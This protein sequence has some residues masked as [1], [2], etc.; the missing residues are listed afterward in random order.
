MVN[1]LNEDIERRAQVIEKALDKVIDKI[2]EETS[3]VKPPIDIPLGELS[4]SPM[5][6]VTKQWLDGIKEVHP[7]LPYSIIKKAHEEDYDH[8]IVEKVSITD[9]AYIALYRVAE[10]IYQ[11][12]EKHKVLIIQSEHYFGNVDTPF[13]MCFVKHDE[14]CIEGFYVDADWEYFKININE[15]KWKPCYNNELLVI[16]TDK[17]GNNIEQ[18]W[19]CILRET[20][21]EDVSALKFFDWI[22]KEERCIHKVFNDWNK[23]KYELYEFFKDMH[24]YTAI[25]FLKDNPGFLLRDALEMAEDGSL[26]FN[27][28]CEEFECDFYVIYER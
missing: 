16:R 7:S 10:T 18:A 14:T 27:D 22:M 25:D 12:L 2:K 19:K 15:T 1:N 13:A 28:P 26:H 17:E 21:G 20:P 5:E 3:V 4:G 11:H 6:Q 23:F 9:E 8:N 24:L